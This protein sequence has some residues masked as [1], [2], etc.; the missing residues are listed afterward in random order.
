ML[1]WSSPQSAS[2]RSTGMPAA[3]LAASFRI[4]FSPLPQGRSPASRLLMTDSQS[5]WASS[6]A[7]SVIEVTVVAKQLEALVGLGAQVRVGT[8]AVEG[9]AVDAGCACEGLDVAFPAGRDVAVQEPG[10]GRP[11][12][13]LVVGE[14]LP[15]EPHSGSPAASSM[16][17]RTRAARSYSACR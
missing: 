11:D 13:R 17:A 8:S 10:H 6:V 3:M 7:P 16:R 4:R 14:L 5:M 12:L 15:A 1:D 2:L 9:G